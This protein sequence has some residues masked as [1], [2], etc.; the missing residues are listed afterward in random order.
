MISD[1]SE[2]DWTDQVEIIGW[3]YQF[4]NTELKQVITGRASSKKIEKD[5]VPAATQLFTPDWIVRYLV[6]NSL[7][8]MW[9]EQNQESELGNKLSLYSSPVVQNDDVIRTI[10]VGENIRPQD[11]RVLDPCMG[12]GH[13]L[14]YLFDVLVLIYEEYGY[15]AREAAEEIINHNLWGIDIDE[16]ASQLAYFAVLMKARHYDRRIFSRKLTPHICAISE[17]NWIDETSINQFGNTPELKAIAAKLVKQFHDAREYGSLLEGIG[18]CDELSNRLMELENDDSIFSHIAR[19]AFYK[20]IDINFILS[21]K[22]DVVCTN[23]PYMGSR[24]GMDSKLKKFVEKHYPDSK[25]DLYACFIEKCIKMTKPHCFSALVTMQSFMFTDDYK[26]LRAK[27]LAKNAFVD[28]MHLGADAFPEINGEVVQT[29]AFVIGKDYPTNYLGSFKRLVDYKCEEKEEQWHNKE[30]V[31][32]A[33]AE[34]FEGIKATPISY[35][36]SEEMRNSFLVGVPFEE[37]GKPR[38]GITT[39]DNDSFLRYW[40][41]VDRRKIGFGSENV[42]S[43]HETHKLYIPYNK[44]GLQVKWYGNNDY[45]IKFDRINYDKLANQGNHLPSRQYYC[46]PCMTWSDIS[47]RSFAARYCNRGFVFDVKGSCGFPDKENIWFSLAL[48]NSKLTP[49]YIDALNPTT[50]TQSVTGTS[51]LLKQLKKQKYNQLFN[52]VLTMVDRKIMSQVEMNRVYECLLQHYNIKNDNDVS[53]ELGEMDMISE[54]EK[55]DLLIHLGSLDEICDDLN[56]LP[57]VTQVY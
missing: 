35:W 18:Y 21:Q 10:S 5:D 25:S 53:D 48:L 31:F 56:K 15:S 7:G 54:V 40:F 32:V 22:Y 39:G 44:G 1:I 20:I 57:N 3:L 50:T 6:D 37:Y 49:K 43:F 52:I 29:V 19:N 36:L 46:L 13:I 51:L 9:I 14:A 27:L 33:S 26:E 34:L 23:P 12:S 11:I 2:A 8:R 38:A 24:K 17:S 16:R 4:Y 42:E 55:Q 28:A 30:N 41:E 47:G 45:V